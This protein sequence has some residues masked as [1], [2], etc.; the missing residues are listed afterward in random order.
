M[1]NGGKIRFFHQH[2]SAGLQII[3]TNHRRRSFLLLMKNSAP[4]P[5]RK[6]NEATAKVKTILSL[7][8]G[9]CSKKV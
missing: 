8:S 2:K 1:S 6:T 9:D 3:K 5:V 7:T 4:N